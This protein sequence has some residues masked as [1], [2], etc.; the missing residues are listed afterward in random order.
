MVTIQVIEKIGE[1]ERGST[2]IF[3]TNRTGQFIIGY[4]KSGTISGNEYHKGLSPYKN[5]EELILMNGE[6]TLDWKNING[7][8]QGTEKLIAPCKVIIPS[9]IWH[10][11]VALTDIVVFELNAL[12]DGQ[13]DTFKIDDASFEKVVA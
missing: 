12:A 7:T 11:L 9:W 2:H 10:K 1:D 8:E 6:A 4:R 3:N 13:G 5:P